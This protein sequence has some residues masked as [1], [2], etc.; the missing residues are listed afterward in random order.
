V[1]ADCSGDYDS[2]TDNEHDPHACD[3]HSSTH[4]YLSAIYA[5]AKSDLLST[6]LY[7]ERICG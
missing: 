7:V 2:Y 1:S 6:K 5:L 3:D 4:P